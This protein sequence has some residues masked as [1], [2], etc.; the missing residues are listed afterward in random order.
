MSDS[1]KSQP[2]FSNLKKKSFLKKGCL[3]APKLHWKNENICAKLNPKLSNII[4]LT[5]IISIS[6]LQKFNEKFLPVLC[7]NLCT[8]TNIM[9]K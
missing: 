7:K 9:C 6:I 1:I 5:I 3:K 4:I 8:T 2:R